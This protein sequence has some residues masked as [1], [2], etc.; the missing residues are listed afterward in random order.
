[1]QGQCDG[2]LAFRAT[3]SW[4]PSG[5]PSADGYVLYRGATSTGRFRA[6][7]SISGR[8]T[9]RYV[10]HGL[11]SGSTYWYV[12]RATDGARVSARSTPASADTP[13]ICLG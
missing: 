4:A 10:D 8:M 13:L 9:T 5:S 2:F 11:G 7:D 12:V 3:V 6:I 1:M